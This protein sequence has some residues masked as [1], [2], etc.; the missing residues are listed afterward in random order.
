MRVP[1][2]TAIRGLRGDT[3]AFRLANRYPELFFGLLDRIEMRS[4]DTK[5]VQT[6]LYVEIRC[7][8][9]YRQQPTVYA[10]PVQTEEAT[11]EAGLSTLNL[12]MHAPPMSPSQVQPSRAL[13][14]RNAPALHSVCAA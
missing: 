6:A 11:V 13:P 9:R 7:A 5:I 3:V 4:S 1:V 8:K 2:L 14:P 10:D 12:S